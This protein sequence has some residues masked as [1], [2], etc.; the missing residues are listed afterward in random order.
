[1]SVLAAADA[2]AQWQFCF[3]MSPGISKIFPVHPAEGITLLPKASI[4]LQGGVNYSFNRNYSAMLL[5]SFSQYAPTWECEIEESYNYPLSKNMRIK[6]SAGIAA[7]FLE[8]TTAARHDF[9]RLLPAIYTSS[10]DNLFIVIKSG[11]QW[12]TPGHR[13]SVCFG[14][15]Y[16]WGIMKAHQAIIYT[17]TNL[18]PSTIIA[19]RG[20]Y[21]ALNMIIF[22]GKEKYTWKKAALVK[23]NHPRH[24][25][26]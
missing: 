12:K 24:F 7:A 11:L 14:A 21:L 17:H 16:H 25:V 22:I 26:M 8:N 13:H 1:M 4:T 5:F 19:G 6:S 9:A 2:S 3:G 20:S 18:S 23:H 10:R 15:D